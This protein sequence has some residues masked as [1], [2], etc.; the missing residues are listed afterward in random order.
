MSARRDA[1]KEAEVLRQQA[2]R[3]LTL[4]AARR[5]ELES[6]EWHEHTDSHEDVLVVITKREAVF[7]VSIAP[8]DFTVFEKRRRAWERAKKARAAEEKK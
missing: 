7:R 5:P 4:W 6:A 1:E 3:L 2:K 8:M